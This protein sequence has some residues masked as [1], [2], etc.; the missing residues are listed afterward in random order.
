MFF[1]IGSLRFLDHYIY[2]MTINV[3][4]YLIFIGSFLFIMSL[5]IKDI[6]A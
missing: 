3:K 6:I 5:V 1:K 2:V 4:G